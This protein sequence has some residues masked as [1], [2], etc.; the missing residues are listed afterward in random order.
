MTDSKAQKA[1]AIDVAYV[2]R[3]ARLRL[4]N[5]ELQTFQGQ[6]DQIVGYFRQI[7]GLDLR[8]TEPTSHTRVLHNVFRRDE[9]RNGLEREKALQNAPA[10]LNDQFS[11]PKIVE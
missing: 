2:A 5:E 10:H 11:V 3:L 7:S 8:G 1:G 9:V 4:T 6:L